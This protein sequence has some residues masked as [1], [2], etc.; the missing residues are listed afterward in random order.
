MFLISPVLE[1]GLAV[2]EEKPLPGVVLVWADLIFFADIADGYLLKQVFAKD[3]Y[4]RG[5]LPL[6]IVPEMRK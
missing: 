3:T 1:R 4:P 5:K 2:F 6:A